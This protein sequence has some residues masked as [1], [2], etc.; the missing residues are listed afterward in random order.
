MNLIESVIAPLHQHV[1]QKSRDETAWR[2]VVEDGHVVDGT[3][4]RQYLGAFRFVENRAIRSFQFTHRTIAVNRYHERVAECA[5][6]SQITHVSHVQKIK[7]AVRKNETR[8]P[9]TQTF[10]LSEHLHGGQ[11]L[12]DH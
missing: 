7:N 3:Q 10:A 11:Y 6:L 1:G 2:N 4:R 8:A 5:C 12:L 9:S